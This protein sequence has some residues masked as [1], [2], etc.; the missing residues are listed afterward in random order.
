MSALVATTLE[1][2]AID[3]MAQALAAAGLPTADLLHPG[4]IFYRFDDG[5]AA[6]GYAGLEGDGADRLLRSLVVLHDRRGAG[7]GRRIIAAVE[8]EALTLGVR[9]LHLL[10]TTAAPFFRACRYVE[11]DRASAPAA[12]AGSTE[13]TALCPASASYFVK[14]LEAA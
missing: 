4:R 11:A 7:L 12:I 10:T 13:F 9:R 2:A 1:A 5:A 6:A 8:R 14:T 3:G